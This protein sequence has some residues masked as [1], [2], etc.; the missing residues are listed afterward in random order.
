MAP[1]LMKLLKPQISV[2]VVRCVA[3]SCVICIN[4]FDKLK[5]RKENEELP[6]NEP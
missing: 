6:R 5:M 4:H 3:F 1:S 2:P